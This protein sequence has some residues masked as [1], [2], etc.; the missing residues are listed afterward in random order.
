MTLCLKRQVLLAPSHVAAVWLREVVTT[1]E[2]R[3]QES[4]LAPA[5]EQQAR[6]PT[7]AAVGQT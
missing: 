4:S 5:A 2:V 7:I 1:V 6:D 3:G